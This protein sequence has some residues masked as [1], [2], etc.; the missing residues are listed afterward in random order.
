MHFLVHE[1]FWVWLP[2]VITHVKKAKRTRFAYKEDRYKV[3]ENLVPF[4]HSFGVGCS[5]P[6]YPT[7]PN[8]Q[9][10]IGTLGIQKFVIVHLEGIR[11]DPNTF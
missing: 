11:I 4:L 5:L 8:K 7:H 2:G 6:S 3:E 1:K 9:R 10:R